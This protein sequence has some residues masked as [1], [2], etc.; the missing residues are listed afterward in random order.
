MGLEKRISGLTYK[1]GFKNAERLFVD[2]V[3]KGGSQISFG[4]HNKALPFFPMFLKEFFPPIVSPDGDLKGLTYF[5]HWPKPEGA[6][7]K[8][9]K[10][11]TK[12]VAAIRDDRIREHGM[13]GWALT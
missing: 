4:I 3:K 11:E 2:Q 10:N 8:D 5:L 12:A 9:S 6:F 1:C 13:C 7:Y